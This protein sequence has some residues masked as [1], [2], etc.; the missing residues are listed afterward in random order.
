M[1]SSRS[2]SYRTLVDSTVSH[3]P[4]PFARPAVTHTFTSVAMTRAQALLLVI[5]DSAILSVDP[6][7]RAFMNYVYLHNG[8]RG[9]EPTWDVN[10]PVLSDADYADELR[11]AMAA[12]MNSV[13][14]QQPAEEDIEA[15]ANVDRNVWLNEDNTDW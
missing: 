12:E 10:A 4:V 5:G 6:L 2:G 7:W 13:I 9:D 1:R 8:W 3:T 14:A 15:E 11:E